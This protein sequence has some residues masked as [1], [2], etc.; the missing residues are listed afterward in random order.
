[1]AQIAITIPDAQLSR[2]IAAFCNSYGYAEAVA[3]T[4]GLTQA[5]FA[6]QQVLA[7]IRS[8]VINYEQNQAVIAAQLIQPPDP[9]LS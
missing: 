3:I 9:G 4:P 2:V 6:K 1:M 7:F 5:Q 8:T